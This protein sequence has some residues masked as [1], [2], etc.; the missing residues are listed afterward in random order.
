[1]N[2][3]TKLHQATDTMVAMAEASGKLD[4][5][6]KSCTLAHCCSEPA[7]LDADEVQHALETP[8]L[9]MEALKRRVQAWLDKVV[10]SGLLNQ[11]MPDA[12]EWRKLNAPC[13][14]LV[15]N[16]CSVYE[17]RPFSC[18]MFFAHGKAENCA[19]PMRVKQK[20]AGFPIELDAQI[21]GPYFASKK[22]IQM[23]NIGVLLAEILLDK[24]I[25]SGSRQEIE[26]V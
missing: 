5:C 7:Y 17:R 13:P 16:R 4:H 21:C 12:I 10:P 23:D 3:V 22:F 26:V 9:D 2:P 25:K 18:R 6:C 1:M 24:K 11:E 19:M 15:D 14:F 8:G 20:F